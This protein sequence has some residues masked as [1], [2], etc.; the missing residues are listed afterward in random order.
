MGQLITEMAS[1][2]PDLPYFDPNFLGPYPDAPPCTMDDLLRLYPQAST[3]SKEDPVAR[4][5]A[6][7]ATAEL[8]AGRPGYRA[9]WKHFVDVS[10]ADIRR[11]YSRMGIQFEQWFGESRYQDRLLELTQKLVDMGVAIESEGALIIPVSK[12]RQ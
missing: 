12:E 5:A 10:I 3:R 11:D 8:Q 6:R 4:E 9:L 7:V 2:H 1:I